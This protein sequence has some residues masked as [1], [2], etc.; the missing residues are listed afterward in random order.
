MAGI[1]SNHRL[2]I[3]NKVIVGV[4]LVF[5][6]GVLITNVIIFVRMGEQLENMIVDKARSITIMGE[7]VRQYTADNWEKG[8]FQ[9]EY[10]VKDIPGKFLYSVPVFSA[11]TTM[12]KKA[13]ELGYQFRVPKN[14]PRNSE[15]EPTPE[16]KTVLDKLE[17]TGADEYVSIDWSNEKI[18]Y[19]RAVKLTKDCLACHGD[20]ATSNELWG[21]TEGKDPTGAAMENWKEGE[22]HGAFALTYDLKAFIAHNNKTRLFVLFINLLII[23]AAVFLIRKIVKNALK[24]LDDMETALAGINQGAGDL[25]QEIRIKNNDE[26]GAVGRQFNAFISQ[27]RGIIIQVRD[28]SAHVA[29]SSGEMTSSSQSLA[30]IAQEQ[31]AVIEQ[32][33]SAMEEI[34][35]TIDSVS[36][37]AKNQAKLANT[38]MTS[39]ES[40]GTSIEKINQ[41]AQNASVMADETR[42]HAQQGEQILGD[43]ISGMKEISNSSQKITEIVTIIADISDQINLLSL[44]ASI[45]AARAGENGRGFAVVAEEISKLADQTST[46]SKEINKLIHETN[47]KVLS[48]SELVEKTAGSL[49][50]IIDNVGKT[51][52]LME[53]IARAS[54]NLASSSEGVI[55]EVAD[56]NR[57]S[58]EISVMMEEQSIS[59]NEI[60][61]AINQINDVTQNVASGSEELAAGS[62]ELSSQSEVMNG[63][64]TRF[65]V[66]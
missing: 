63:I 14:H 65:K 16:E 4:L 39:M 6:I 52:A 25:T 62:E 38:T 33:S 49:K 19:F 64:V 55:K 5:I 37:N 1:F 21:N 59:S 22:V 57:M 36:S 11:I 47:V 29:S 56:V 7:A 31:A 35:A 28:A 17:Q 58:E 15:N 26:V 42:G 12:K 41:N 27:L 44:N 8:V 40:L 32:T 30:N 34:K 48:G 2:S 53:E 43:T 61:K 9:R 18:R 54:K 3:K 66:Q 60:I 24:P 50:N 13:E 51:A 46:S 23:S 45:E 20:P 10:L